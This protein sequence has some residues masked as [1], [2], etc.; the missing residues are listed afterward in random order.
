MIHLITS[1][2]KLTKAL[3]AIDKENVSKSKKNQKKLTLLKTQIIIR[4][5]VLNQ[6]LYCIFS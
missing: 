5:Y 4:K 2:N 1:P 6:D 3:V